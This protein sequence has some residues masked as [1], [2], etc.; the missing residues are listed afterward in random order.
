VGDELPV[1]GL[2]ADGHGL[3]GLGDGADLVELDQRRRHRHGV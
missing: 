1:S 3:E 2:A